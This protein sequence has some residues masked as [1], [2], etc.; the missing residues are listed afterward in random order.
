MFKWFALLLGTLLAAAILVL[1]VVTWIE[2]RQARELAGKL[3]YAPAITSASR[4]AVVYKKQATRAKKIHTA[5][6][7]RILRQ[8]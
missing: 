4:T 1:L 7:K 3:P 8:R 6:P 2:S 5:P